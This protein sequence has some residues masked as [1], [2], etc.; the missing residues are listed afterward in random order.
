MD[1]LKDK[2]E[3]IYKQ[4]A[5]HNDCGMDAYIHRESLNLIFLPSRNRID[6]EDFGDTFNA[7]YDEV[8]NNFQQ[9]ILIEPPNSNESYGIM[10]DFV[11]HLNEGKLK[12][13]LISAL[14]KRKP[15][16]NF[17]FIIDQSPVREVWF[18]FKYDQLVNRVEQV[19]KYQMPGT[20]KFYR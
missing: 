9:Y 6:I 15:F 18:K 3:E 12:K 1:V 7:D 5:E 8:D 20:N 2:L 11:E 14:R 10:E 19:F 17:K 13:S 16:A 4:I